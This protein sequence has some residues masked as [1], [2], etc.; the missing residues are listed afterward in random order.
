[1]FRPT[2]N[3]YIAWQVFLGILTAFVIIASVILLIDFVE[4]SR[5]IGESD[6]VGIGQVAWL[7]LLKA[8]Q[9][10]Q[11]T[12]PFIV[13]FGVM[14]ALFRLNR[15]SELII[16][17]A[18]G[19]SA[20]RFLQPALIVTGL[21]GVIWSTALNPFA[22]RTAQSFEKAKASFTQSDYGAADTS[23]AKRD[24]IWLQEGTD[25]GR[26][27]IF[28]KSGNIDTRI[29]TDVTF[30]QFVYDS[31]R[32]PVFSGRYD[33]KTATLSQNGYWVLAD[34]TETFVNGQNPQPYEALS[35]PTT[36][37]WASLREATGLARTPQ[38]WELPAEIAKVKQAGFSSRSLVLEY[39][40]LLALPITLMA[41]A[42]IAAGVSMQLTRLG[43]T[44]RLMIIGAAL[45]FGVYFAN[46]LI[47]AFGETG[48]LPTLLAAWFVPALVLI[49]G[50]FRLCLIEDG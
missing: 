35:T 26:T 20:W 30:F 29:L 16:M 13:L 1:M 49:G 40:K 7:T 14:T 41:M 32:A 45:G 12:I 34:V 50:L 44:L 31:Q 3:L 25:I 10:M 28:A 23:T 19:L 18:A 36:M 48:A 22:A 9:L 8:P 39:N 27:R 21:I 46:N 37:T 11:E 5:T 6:S 43:G 42:I 38:F 24:N 2:L 17:R 4:I 15:R 47:T 33:A